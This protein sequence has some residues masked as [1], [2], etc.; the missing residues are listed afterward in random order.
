MNYTTFIHRI[1]LTKNQQK[2]I[3]NAADPFFRIAL[4]FRCSD[5]KSVIQ[6]LIF[7]TSAAEYAYPDFYAYT[8]FFSN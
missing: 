2:N 4:H 5:N 6:L 8:S 7:Y 3:G 1:N